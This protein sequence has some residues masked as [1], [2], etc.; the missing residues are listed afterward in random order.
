[1]EDVLLTS[2]SFFLSS[3]KL[4]FLVASL[5]FLHNVLVL[6]LLKSHLDSAFER[7][8]SAFMYLRQW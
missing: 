1:M 5:D 6:C 8:F 3:L 2:L 4:F 7:R